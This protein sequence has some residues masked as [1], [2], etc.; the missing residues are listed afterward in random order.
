MKIKCAANERMA[1]C[2]NRSHYSVAT[3][4]DAGQH[5]LIGRSKVSSNGSTGK[6]G[7]G[8][9]FLPV[10]LVRTPDQNISESDQ[11]FQENLVREDHFYR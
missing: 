2:S 1:A 9:Q 11:F 7:S 5:L 8:G 4:A 10:I 6:I 3:I